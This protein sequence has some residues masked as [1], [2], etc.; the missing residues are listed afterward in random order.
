[1]TEQELRKAASAARVAQ[2]P[3]FTPADFQGEWSCVEETVIGRFGKPGRKRQT[4]VFEVH[5]A[6]EHARTIFLT[7]ICDGKSPAE[8]RK[9]AA[10]GSE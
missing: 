3:R 5:H 7:A 10:S 8:C 4:R 9:L 2:L 1:M 6:V